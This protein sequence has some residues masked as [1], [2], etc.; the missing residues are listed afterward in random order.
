MSGKHS[1]NIGLIPMPQM[2]VK[3]ILT[4]WQGPQVLRAIQTCDNCL[5]RLVR[6][7]DRIQSHLSGNRGSGA[8]FMQVKLPKVR[9]LS[10]AIIIQQ[11]TQNLFLSCVC[12]IHIVQATYFIVF[13][14]ISFKFSIDEFNFNSLIFVSNYVF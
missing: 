9:K 14:V 13:I 1:G 4:C 8:L 11:I 12:Q 3:V 5:K 7:A 6:L 2:Q 10:Y